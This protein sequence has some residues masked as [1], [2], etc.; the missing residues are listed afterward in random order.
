MAGEMALPSEPE[1]TK[2]EGRFIRQMRIWQT[3]STMV[4]H[5]SRIAGDRHYLMLCGGDASVMAVTHAKVQTINNFCNMFLQPV[6]GKLSDRYGRKL[7]LAAG[8]IG[9]VVWF[10]LLPHTRTLAQRTA[11]E[12]LTWG[13]LSA[14]N[15][16]VFGAAHPTSSGRGRTSPGR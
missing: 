7:F 13:V 2:E 11:L 5:V 10:A 16:T 12:A 4:F 6:V 3:M 15:W 14:G 1:L 8:K 9:W